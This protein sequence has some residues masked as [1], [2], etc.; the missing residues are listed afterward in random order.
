MLSFLQALVTNDVQVLHPGQGVYAAYLTPQGRMLADLKIHHCGEY[1]LAEVQDGLASELADRFDGLIFTED[2]RVS[3]VSSSTAQIAVIGE[4]AAALLAHAFALEPLQPEQFTTL[5]V[6]GHIEIAG[7]II[8]RTDDADLPAFEVFVEDEAYH[9]TV[10]RLEEMGAVEGSTELL[11]ALR[12]EA[13]RP[14]F[15]LDMTNGTIPLEAGL[16]ERAISTTKGCYVGQEIIVRVL[17]RGG[18]RVAKRLVKLRFDPSVETPPA[19]G[20][21]LFHGAREIGR[22]TSAA[23]SP[24][25]ERVIALGYVHREQA[26]PGVQVS[27]A[28]DTGGHQAE[29]VGLAG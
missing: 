9:T 21:A 5:P 19:A 22:I 27:L 2:V 7:A 4:K 6:L 12:I 24:L 18:G 16:L 29:I 1:L 20:S 14:A 13:G 8:A 11:E 3:D 17:H 15:G 10:Q 26:E 28:P 25:Q 23:V